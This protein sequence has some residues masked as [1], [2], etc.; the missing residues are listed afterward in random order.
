MTPKELSVALNR[1]A[2]KIDASTNPSRD[3]VLADVNRILASMEVEAGSHEANLGKTLSK[4]ALFAVLGLG[5]GTGCTEAEKEQVKDFMAHQ[6]DIRRDNQGEKNVEYVKKA[7]LK[8]ISSSD[9]QE[10][11]TDIVR[12]S[13][14]DV[15]PGPAIE[16]AK[17]KLAQ[18]G[19]TDPDPE[20][21]FE[22]VTDDLEVTIVEPSEF[23]KGTGILPLLMIKYP[24]GRIMDYST[25]TKK[26]DAVRL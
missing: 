22:Q 4:A 9:W 1:I 5:S 6:L 12:F 24:N 26:W 21:I 8:G 7:H 20:D 17:M 25:D 19:I 15:K 16:S 11:T 13:R 3:L 23:I 10:L 2:S 14:G 18:K